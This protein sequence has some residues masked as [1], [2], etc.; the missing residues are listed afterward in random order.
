[1]RIFNQMT[2]CHRVIDLAEIIARLTG[3]DIDLVPNPRKEASANDLLVANDHL[4]KLGLDPITLEDELMTEVTEIAARYADRCD[5]DK[6]PARSLWRRQ[7]QA[8]AEPQPA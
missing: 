2:E 4:L 5:R 1:V 6:I 3:A 7:K 8:E